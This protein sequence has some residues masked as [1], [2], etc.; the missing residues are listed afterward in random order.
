VNFE[1]YAQRPAVPGAAPD[2][3][4]FRETTSRNSQEDRM[5]TTAVIAS[6]CAALLTA[7]P[8][9]FASV[10]ATTD[11]A[12][13]AAFQVGATIVTFEGIPGITAFHNQTPGTVVP[14][15]ALLKNQVTG[16]TFFSNA[17]EGPYVLDLTGFGNIGDAHSTPNVVAGTSPEG[18]AG[19]AVV[20]FTCFVE[21]RFASPVS[22]VGARN[23]PTGSRIQLLATDAGGGTTFGDVQADQGQ[24]VGVD[25]GVNNI[26]RALFQFISTQSVQ[27]FSLDD[28]TFARAGT[29]TVP[30][31][32]TLVLGGLGLAGVAWL[33]R[34]RP[35]R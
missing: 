11:P 2:L 5:R 7:P 30:E 15:A 21:I 32:G 12:Q 1:R 8:I 31:P 13:I 26:E 6:L 22:R 4:S 9:G 20:C 34:R 23:D 19:E 24:F 10:I 18:P 17:I 27:G 29:T 35:P 16:L 25:T 14:S 28:L 3:L 33:R